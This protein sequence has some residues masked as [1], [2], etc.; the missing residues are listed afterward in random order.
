MI[1]SLH[2][3]TEAVQGLG[4]LLTSLTG[5]VGAAIRLLRVLDP[6]VA[7]F[8]TRPSE[9]DA[10]LR[11][12]DVP[13]YF[14]AVRRYRDERDWK[15]VSEL[16]PLFDFRELPSPARET[17][18]TWLGM[19]EVSLGR[20]E[21][22]ID[23]FREGIGVCEY[24][25]VSVE[26][27]SNLGYTLALTGDFAAAREQNDIALSID[28]VELALYNALAIESMAE[29]GRRLDAR[30]AALVDRF[31]VADEPGSEL[32]KSVL[33]DPDLAWFRSQASFQVNFPKLAAA[34]TA[35]NGDQSKRGAGAGLFAGL[36]LVFALGLGSHSAMLESPTAAPA[37]AVIRSSA[38][39]SAGL[40]SHAFEPTWASGLGSHL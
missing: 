2:Q 38:L 31:P 11:R 3:I 20:H 18:L 32:S 39:L 28:P 26:L 8:T 22:G 7:I 19:A 16:G 35:A 15:V 40:G 23:H 33:E 27:H 10:E 25:P 9:Y 37:D 36:G 29:N 1:K 14:Y 6:R 34:R 21:A 13:A 24:E 4:A 17:Y 12:K 5:G 30:A